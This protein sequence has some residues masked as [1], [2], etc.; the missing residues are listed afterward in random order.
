MKRGETIA[1]G[2][3]SVILIGAVIWAQIVTSNW[4]QDEARV[5]YEIGY[6]SAEGGTRIAEGVCNV[7]GVIV[8]VKR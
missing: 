3:F 8:E 5:N 7:N 1:I 2:I 4:K 6:C